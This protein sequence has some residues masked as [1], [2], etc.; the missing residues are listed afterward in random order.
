MP[1]LAIAPPLQQS[2]QAQVRAEASPAPIGN[3]AA[4]TFKLDI[5]L[6]SNF[7]LINLFEIM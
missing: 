5:E 2:S 1:P 6:I 7:K 4:A 3:P